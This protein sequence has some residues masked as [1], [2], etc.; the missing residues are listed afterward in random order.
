MHFDFKGRRITGYAG[1]TIAAALCASG[2]KI[3]SR[4]LK[5]HRP[6]GLFC[7][8]G[9]C[10]SCL[11]S[12]NGVNNVRT[13]IEPAKE[14]IIV[15]ENDDRSA[16]VAPIKKD[17]AHSVEK[18]D[19]DLLVVGGGPA[20]LSAAITAAKLG[21]DSVIV[22]ENTLPG[23]QL[24]KQSHKFFGT[25]DTYA[26]IR[27]VEI[28]KILLGDLKKT[29][30]RWLLN[31]SVIGCFQ[32]KNH[33]IMIVQENEKL[34]EANAKRV[35]ISTGAQENSLPFANNDLPGVYGAGAVQ[36]L[37]NVYGIL[38]G[39]KALI[40]GAGNV[41][42]IVGYQLIQAGVNVQMVVEAAPTIGGYLVHASKL[43]RLGVPILTSHTIKSAWGNESV[44]GATIVELD[45]NWQ[46]IKGSDQ[47]VETDMICIAVGLSPSSEL[48]SQA[49]CRQTYMPELGGLVAIHSRTL[50]TTVEGMLV[51]GDASGIQEA[52]TAIM[53][54]RLAAASIA[55][56]ENADNREASR[57]VEQ[58]LRSLE[59]LRQS[60]SSARVLS[61][62]KKV[63]ELWSKLK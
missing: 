37:M 20:G 41:G 19:T 58:S 3:L 29:T 57:I 16:R 63:N 44:E 51:S 35:L 45:K 42:L 10:S 9:K 22:D 23:G 24:I 56:Q 30:T 47:R 2:I 14:G 6:R 21:V 46:E 54:G 39:K 11:M 38:P 60:P 17:L 34:I 53:E 50:E 27:G 48:T 55:T 36:T 18:I 4:S 32:N 25:K 8:I 59:S 61:G 26:G 62:K 7:C 43:R 15:E 49:G 5:Y 1:E 31:S 52:N 13:C 33:R 40:V 28:A 12:V